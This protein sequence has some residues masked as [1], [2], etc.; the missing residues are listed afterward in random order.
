M[1]IGLDQKVYSRL[2]SLGVWDYTDITAIGGEAGSNPS[3]LR[4]RNL[5]TPYLSRKGKQPARVADRGV[6]KRN[7][8]KANA[9]TVTDRI[10]IERKRHHPMRKQADFHVVFLYKIVYRTF[11]GGKANEYR[12]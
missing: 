4:M 8:E 6:G 1:L 12:C 7:V 5:G 11:E 10:R 3:V 9:G 2:I